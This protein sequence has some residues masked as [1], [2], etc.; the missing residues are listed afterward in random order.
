MTANKISSLYVHVPFCAAFCYYCDFSRQIYR[1]DTADRWLDALE[2]EIRGTKIASDLET[3]YIGG[4]TPSCL[5][6]EQTERLLCMLDPYAGT[7]REYTV[8]CNPELN[9][10]NRIRCFAR[11]GVNRISIGL[12]TSDSGLLKSVNRR[13]DAD[14]AKRL[15]NQFFACGISNISL[16][17]MYGLP[18]QTVEQLD[19][20][21]SFALAC[22]PKHL[23]LYSLTVEPGSVFGKNGV[24]QI[25][26]DL[27]ADMYEQICRTLERNGFM[28]YEVSNFALPGYE[29]VHNTNVWHYDD[30]YGIGYGAWGKD[31]GGRYEH[32]ASLKEYCRDPLYRN[33]TRLSRSE[34]MFEMLM[35]GLRLK[36][37]I[38]LPVFEQ[39]YGISF[40]DAFP[41]TAKSLFDRGLLAQADG[42]VF[43]TAEGWPL[44]NSLLVEFMEE[45]GL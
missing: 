32:A 34:Q 45:A 42:Y 18:G 9:D 11:H 39:R 19:D 15:V 10:E 3:I 41:K 21:I 2:Q 35:M 36:S 33:Y 29:S 23:S 37:G 30:F 20:S 43:C 7:V 44:L 28:H 31:S 5:N 22:Q 12:Q 8:E 17:L 38:S 1:S 27:E 4:G 14:D 6:D 16:D 25:D 13:H 24:K 26:E 40:A